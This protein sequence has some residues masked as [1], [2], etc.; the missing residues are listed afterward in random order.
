MILQNFQMNSDCVRMRWLVHVPVSPVD[1]TKL[2][3][4][5]RDSLDKRL[6]R[7]FFKIYEFVLKKE[8]YIS[9]FVILSTIILMYNLYVK[10]IVESITTIEIDSLFII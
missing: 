2:V 10:I 7:C 9:I 5:F 4:L 8:M 3:F 6:M 1:A